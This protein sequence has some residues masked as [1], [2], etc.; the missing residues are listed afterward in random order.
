L[1][2]GALLAACSSSGSNWIGLEPPSV[3]KL[4]VNVTGLPVGAEG[5]I[6]VSGPGG[7]Q[8]TLSA[9]GVLAG[10]RPGWYQLAAGSAQI[11][12]DRYEALEAVR[13]IQVV[14]GDLPAQTEVSYRVATGRLAVAIAGLPAGAVA[15]VQV[16]GPNGYSHAVAECDTLAGLIP[17]AYT[18]AASAVVAAG[19][20]YVPATATLTVEISPS[21]SP[22]TAGV[23][24]STGLGALA[25][26]IDGLPGGTDAQVALTGPGGFSRLLRWSEALANL[27]P[28]TY[29]LT[30]GSVLKD[31][32]TYLAAPAS[33]SVPIAGGAA[34]PAAI[35]Y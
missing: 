24:Y 31:G 30:A 20:S 18:V 2:L 19:T 26:S 23:T 35:I 25:V 15:A 22:A 32:T 14:A 17:G 13:A 7:F 29:Q 1:L 28:G 10:R 34:T 4:A 5:S 16:S 33:Q 12:G 8:R 11:E 27:Q 9:S 21:P 6:V 3:G